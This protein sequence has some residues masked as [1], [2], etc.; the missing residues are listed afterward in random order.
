MPAWKHIGVDNVT[1]IN[2]STRYM[3]DQL[4]ASASVP[5]EKKAWY[6]AE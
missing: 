4:P 6:P 5:R 3:S 1:L 2:A